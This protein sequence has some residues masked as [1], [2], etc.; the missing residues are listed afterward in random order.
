MIKVLNDNTKNKLYTIC[1][2]CRSELEYDY[3]DVCVSPLNASPMF[4]PNRVVICPCCNFETFAELS[5]KE[6]YNDNFSNIPFPNCFPN[7]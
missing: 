3:S 1:K 4:A 6:N 7:T 5:T 2:G